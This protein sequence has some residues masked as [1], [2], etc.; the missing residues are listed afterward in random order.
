MTRKSKKVFLFVLIL[1]LIFLFIFSRRALS[2]T[3]NQQPITK[4]SPS[5]TPSQVFSS[6]T[7]C[8]NVVVSAGETVELFT[9]QSG[10][11]TR[12]D[13]RVAAMTEEKAINLQVFSDG[14]WLYVWNQPH[15]YNKDDVIVNPPG[16]KIKLSS[17]PLVIATSTLDE[18]KRISGSNISGD[19]LCYPWD[20]L[21][22]VFKVPADFTFEDS[23][24][25]TQKIKEDLS[26]ICQ[27][28]SKTSNE[29]AASA[30]RTNLSCL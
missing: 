30:C 2:P 24:E 1:L 6:T 13:Y 8:Q 12:F 25:T 20:D 18:V 4:N 29:T 15:R 19:R 11:F 28:C 22:P 21:D 14:Q 9:Y 16:K 17:P 5:P 3:K 26:K 7:K 27:I 10:N 23:N